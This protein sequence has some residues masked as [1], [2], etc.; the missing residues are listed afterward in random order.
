M[1]DEYFGDCHYDNSRVILDYNLSYIKFQFRIVFV[2]YLAPLTMFL[3]V[4]YIV[5]FL[6][7]FQFFIYLFIYLFIYF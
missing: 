3:F 7:P 2:V 5:V 6:T 4:L 1:K